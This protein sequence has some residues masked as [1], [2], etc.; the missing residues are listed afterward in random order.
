MAGHTAQSWTPAWLGARH[1]YSIANFVRS[2]VSR[3]CIMSRLMKEVLT[4]YELCPLKPAPQYEESTTG[5]SSTSRLHLGGS[6]TTTSSAPLKLYCRHPASFLEIRVKMYRM[7]P[8]YGLEGHAHVDGGTVEQYLGV[9][10]DGLTDANVGEKTPLDAIAIFSCHTSN[11]A[12]REYSFPLSLSSHF[13][14]SRCAG[15]C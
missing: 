7:N 13:Q 15:R 3:Q 8:H 10:A 14:A 1:S 9:S 2:L 5:H 6:T 4:D 11:F 12:H